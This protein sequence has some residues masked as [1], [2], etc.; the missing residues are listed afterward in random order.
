MQVNAVMHKQALRIKGVTLHTSEGSYTLARSNTQ[1]QTQTHLHT[2]AHAHTHTHTHT[3]SLRFMHKR[4]HTTAERP[5]YKGI[6]STKHQRGTL[7]ISTWRK[8]F[9]D[10]AVFPLQIL[11]LAPAT[12]QSNAGEMQ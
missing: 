5:S 12:A 8:D 3:L 2:D 10:C 7:I 11:T 1:A 4:L 9:T 6:H